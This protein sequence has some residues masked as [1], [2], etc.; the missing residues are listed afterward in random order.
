[1][2]ILQHWWTGCREELILFQGTDTAVDVSDGVFS[3]VSK[4]HGMQH[5]FVSNLNP[6]LTPK[7]W[8]RLMD[9]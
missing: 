1:M 6:N 3:N 4:L 7:N 2:K 8:E 9:L 5:D